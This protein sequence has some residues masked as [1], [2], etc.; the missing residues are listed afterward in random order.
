MKNLRK[1]IAALMTVV[2]FAGCISFNGLAAE[3]GRHWEL[4]EDGE[5]R[6][7]IN[8]EM[9]TNKMISETKD[10]VKKTYYLKEDGVMASDEIFTVYDIVDGQDAEYTCYAYPDG[11]LAFKQW[12]KLNDE[13]QL[14]LNSTD[15]DWYYFGSNGE[16]FEN[17][18]KKIAGT[19]YLF[20]Q[21]GKMLTGFQDWEEKDGEGETTY[22]FM[23]DGARAEGKWLYIEDN[24]YSF[25]SDGTHK[26]ASDSNATYSFDDDGKL[27]SDS[28]HTPC[29][30]V[31]TITPNGETDRAVEV[32]QEVK[33][34]FDV[35]LA[36]ASNAIEQGH[37]DN[38]DWWLSTASEDNHDLAQEKTQ[39]F[40]NGKVIVTYTPKMPNTVSF[41]AVI[42]GVEAADAITVVSDWAK[43]EKADD[44][45]TEVIA[46]MLTSEDIESAVSTIKELSKE[47]EDSGKV[48]STLMKESS[49]FQQLDASYAMANR[50]LITQ[51]TSTTAKKLMGS[52]SVQLIGGSLNAGKGETVEL[53]VDKGE[54][55]ELPLNYE[56]Q[57]SFGLNFYVGGSETS[58][59]E[60]PVVIKMPI[61]S[62]M[63]GDGLKV[64]HMAADGPELLDI[65]VNENE[66]T[67]V[68]D[69][70]SDYVFAGKVASSGSTGGNTSNS[71][72]SSSSSSSN[73]K[74][75]KSSIPETPGSWKKLD[76]GAWQFLQANG[77]PYVNT[78]VYVNGQWYWINPSGFMV[79]GWQNI[80][81]KR[82]YLD[83]V[84]GAMKQGWLLDGTS[85]YYLDNTG[86]MQTGWV[87]VGG[88]WY[89][90]NND[91]VM[92][93]NNMTPDG[94]Q[95][96][97]SGAW[98][99]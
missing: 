2:L 44:Q 92:M 90:M 56:K 64:Y 15:G 12:V 69:S 80:N 78:W 27:S 57:V 62:G 7:W 94:Y 49:A 6:L 96:D 10:G 4:S 53:S 93:L 95:V 8:G 91:G 70:F 31:D 87:S 42:D 98:I 14:A 35:Q 20:D 33:L 41:K 55:A 86:A 40:E 52:G 39:K 11:H 77:T 84:S 59:L 79:E 67:F 36:S 63:S 46:N 85:W 89:Y 72:S 30:T 17:K 16:R 45:K 5:W 73:R 74:A 37:T 82:Y 65:K 76:N 51:S 1:Q 24:W 28:P 83:P 43:G 23:R 9:K 47:V 13:G 81:G 19:V 21:D 34:T 18:M 54:D 25:N 66:V 26:I 88:K 58:K 3:S 75:A 50:N 97:S 38:H 22:Y 99:K 60:V 32:G 68:T 61:P 71:S 29:R 48:K